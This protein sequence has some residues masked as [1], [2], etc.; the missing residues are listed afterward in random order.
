MDAG[1]SDVQW[2]QAGH[3]LQT[4]RA[5]SQEDP[6][7]TRSGARLMPQLSDREPLRV[8]RR[9]RF[10]TPGT[11]C[12]GAVRTMRPQWE[13]ACDGILRPH[14]AVATTPLRCWHA[15]CVSACQEVS[16]MFPSAAAI[17]A[18]IPM[19]IDL[20]PGLVPVLTMLAVLLVGALEIARSMIDERR[21]HDLAVRHQRRARVARPRR[22]GSGD[23]ALAA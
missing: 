2:S 22:A 19:P 21:A 12:T 15:T 3:G 17:A 16:I 5:E 9:T 6:I 4:S 7:T 18:S 10:V 13:T 23:R 1:I 8:S 14:R 20:S 11:G